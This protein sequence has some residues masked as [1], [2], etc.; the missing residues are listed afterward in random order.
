MARKSRSPDQTTGTAANSIIMGTP[1]PKL[2]DEA[3]MASFPERAYRQ[4]S[5]NIVTPT[6]NPPTMAETAF[7]TVRRG[8]TSVGAANDVTADMTRPVITNNMMGTASLDRRSN[9]LKP[10]KATA[11]MS[12]DAEMR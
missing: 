11:V 4:T 10:K 2:N 7:A 5:G 3:T 1:S 12:N 9:P 6:L 8:V